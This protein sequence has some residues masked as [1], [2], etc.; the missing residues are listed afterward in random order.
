MRG[1]S[2]FTQKEEYETYKTKMYDKQ[3]NIIADTAEEF[4]GPVKTD[5]SGR[6]YSDVEPG[7]KRSK[8][9]WDKGKKTYIKEEEPGKGKYHYQNR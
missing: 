1:W 4:T 2:P 7:G 6:K 3:G 8:V 9:Y 5:K